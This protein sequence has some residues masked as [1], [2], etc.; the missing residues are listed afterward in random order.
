MPLKSFGLAV[1]TFV[2]QNVG[3]GNRDRLK[4]G[5]PNTLF[6][7]MV[8]CLSLSILL[9]AAA[10]S[11]VRLFS[12][13]ADVIRVGVDAMRVMLPFYVMMA[14]RDVC[15]GVL[16]GFG[17]TAVPMVL[18]VLGMVGLRQLYLAL[19]LTFDRDILH[20][21]IGFPLAWSV[22]SVMI[23]VYFFMRKSRLE[24]SVRPGKGAADVPA[25]A[26]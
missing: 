18:S 5:F 26:D 4:R 11:C 21:Y 6:L 23:T 19:A 14:L 3:A 25:C 8:Y 12:G 1:T 10:E 20:I 24:N 13:D 7:S 22:T 15:L 16:R 9:Y 2:G 17:D